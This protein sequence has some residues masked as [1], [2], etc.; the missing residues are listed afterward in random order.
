MDSNIEHIIDIGIDPTEPDI[1]DIGFNVILSDIDDIGS[2]MIKS[3]R[4]ASVSDPI[5]LNLIRLQYLAVVELTIITYVT[6]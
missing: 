3:D 2:D 5:R 4:I 6:R 1:I